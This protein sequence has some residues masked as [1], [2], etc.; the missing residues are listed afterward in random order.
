MLLLL[1]TS[2]KTPPMTRPLTILLLLLLCGCQSQPPVVAP[3]SVQAITPPMV[4]AVK[5]PLVL[6][7]TNT[8]K[9]WNPHHTL[10]WT[11]ATN[12]FISFVVI[13]S[14]DVRVPLAQWPVFGVSATNGFSFD[15]TNG[16]DFFF[17]R[18]SNSIAGKLSKL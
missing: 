8:A 7:R 15:A 17:V 13:H 12:Q 18:A 9:P 6:T 1:V 5:Q 3:A 14:N 10:V 4:M 16:C 2:C 11:A